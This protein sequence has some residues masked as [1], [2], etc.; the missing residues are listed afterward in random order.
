[1]KVYISADIEGIGGVV[2]RSQLSHEGYDYNRA[3]KLM[4]GEVN[5]A[6]KGAFSGGANDVLVNDS[7]GPMTN[8]L[9][10]ELH[11]EARL[12]TGNQKHLGMMQGIDNT[13]DAVVLVGYH[14]RHNTAGVLSHSYHGGVIN[15]ICLNGRAVGELEFN[16]YIAG[17]YDVPV[18]LVSGDDMMAEQAKVLNSEIETV[19]VKNAVSR[20]TANCLHPNKIHKLIEKQLK[21][22]LKEGP[23]TVAS[24]KLE[25]PVELEVTF[26]NSGMAENA[27]LMPGSEMVSPN[28]VKYMAKDVIDAFKV[29]LI[30]TTLGAK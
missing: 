17:Y 15:K 29:F 26:T 23:K 20:Y 25:G 9:I 3:R 6:I 5:A 18:V 27:L 1:M 28:A 2:D 24:C 14:A 7:H 4:T 19:I 16:S 13:F 21:Q 11:E 8:L 30:L 22:V 12:I 10:E